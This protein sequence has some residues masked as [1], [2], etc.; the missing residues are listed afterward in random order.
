MGRRKRRQSN[1]KD[2]QQQKPNSGFLEKIQTSDL[3]TR[4]QSLPPLTNL[5][6]HLS[7]PHPHD[8]PDHDP[9]TPTHLLDEQDGPTTRSRDSTPRP[10]KQ[11]DTPITPNGSFSPE[12]SELIESV[13]RHRRN[14]SNGSIRSHRRQGSNGSVASCGG[15]GGRGLSLEATPLRGSNGTAPS[16]KRGSK[17]LSSHASSR[18]GSN[19]GT[20]GIPYTKMDSDSDNPD[21]GVGVPFQRPGGGSGC[22]LTGHPPVEHAALAGTKDGIYSNESSMDTHGSD[23]EGNEADAESTSDGYENRFDQF[24]GTEPNETAESNL[25]SPS[26]GEVESD[27]TTSTSVPDGTESNMTTSLIPRIHSKK[28][29]SLVPTL[30]I[31]SLGTGLPGDIS[32]DDELV[33]R[34]NALSLEQYMATPTSDL[35]G[36]SHQVAMLVSRFEQSWPGGGEGETTDAVS[37]S[38]LT[39]LVSI[40]VHI[41]RQHTPERQDDGKYVV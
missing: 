9:A 4:R 2:E 13:K 38:S 39:G 40:P 24:S 10:H 5:P 26:L 29:N 6:L 14:A 41:R 28:Q 30:P 37:D 18:R 20:G 34:D 32:H 3:L 33:S 22:G 23:G 11:P 1:S 12:V 35:H 16:S 17:D 21:G 27:E 36:D 19:S 7:S 25:E 31:F 15:V 8:D